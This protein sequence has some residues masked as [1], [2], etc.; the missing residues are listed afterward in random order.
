MMAERKGILNLYEVN[1][2]KMECQSAGV[3]RCSVERE[4]GHKKL[5]LLFADGEISF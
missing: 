4:M 5:C 1:V 2:S 3:V